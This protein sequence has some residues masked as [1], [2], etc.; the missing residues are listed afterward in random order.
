MVRENQRFKMEARGVGGG[1]MGGRY[2]DWKIATSIEIKLTFDVSS[3][4]RTCI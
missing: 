2:K 1:G 4:I 3:N